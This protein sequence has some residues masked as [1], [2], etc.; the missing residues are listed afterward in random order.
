MEKE[1]YI[2]KFCC[3]GYSKNLAR[4]HLFTMT[5]YNK[6]VKKHGCS[7]LIYNE[8]CKMMNNILDTEYFNDYFIIGIENVK[9]EEPEYFSL[10]LLE[11]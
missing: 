3:K 1:I 6:Y 4:K 2:C 8:H 7:N 9:R 5:H 10:D 11:F